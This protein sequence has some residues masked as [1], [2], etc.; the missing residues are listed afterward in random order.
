MQE[1]RSAGSISPVAAF[2]LRVHS[3]A[4]TGVINGSHRGREEGYGDSS[5][6][7]DTTTLDHHHRCHQLLSIPLTLRIDQLSPSKAH[8]CV[9]KCPIKVSWNATLAARWSWCPFAH[10]NAS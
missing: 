6:S 1:E 8:K 7:D 5:D 3:G 9:S 10:L 2:E 4:V